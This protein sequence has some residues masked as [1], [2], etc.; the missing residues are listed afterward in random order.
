MMGWGHKPFNQ[1]KDHCK[2][3]NGY[4]IVMDRIVLC[5]FQWIDFQQ[6]EI[7]GQTDSFQLEGD[8]KTLETLIKSDENYF[9]CYT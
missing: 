1:F 7:P 6:F 5:D 3:L 9:F 8:L 4:L 2:S